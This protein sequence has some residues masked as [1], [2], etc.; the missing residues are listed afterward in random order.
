MIFIVFLFILPSLFLVTVRVIVKH[1]PKTKFF[2]NWSRMTA[3]TLF[4]MYEVKCVGLFWDLPKLISWYENL[5]VVLGAAASLGL[6]LKLKSDFRKVTECQ[7]RVCGVCEVHVRGKDHHCVWLDM[8]IYSDNI[9]IFLMF[10]LV[11]LLTSGHLCLLLTS[12]SCPGVL[13][14]PLLLPQ[15]CWP[16]KHSDQL[17]LSAGIYSGIISGLIFVLLIGQCC[18]KFR[19][20]Q[21]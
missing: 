6:Y 9:N 13:L 21:L 5:V 15:L 12:C 16:Y 18:R 2:I 14:A 20:N 7:G 1:K 17:L 4:Y 3:L 8:C 10:L 11:T 19:N